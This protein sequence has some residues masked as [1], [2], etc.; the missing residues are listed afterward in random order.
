MKKKIWL[1]KDYLFENTE[2]YTAGSTLYSLDDQ[3][4]AYDIWNR[5]NSLVEKN[6]TLFDLTDGITNLK[7]SINHRLKLIEKMYNFKKI[8]F[9]EKP[10][11]YLELL[12]TYN[13]VRPYLIKFVM[14]IRNLIEHNDSPPPNKQRCKELVDMV[15]YFLK[16]TDSIVSRLTTDFEFEVYDKNNNETHYGGTVELDYNTHEIIKLFGWFPS[17]AI[18]TEKREE[19]LCICTNSFHGNEK[20]NDTEYHHDKLDTDL[21]INGTIDTKCFDYHS[22]ILHLLTSAR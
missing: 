22:L 9:P 8:N 3:Q 18:S 16:S 14:E 20:W 2:W 6:E 21:Y 7:R 12:E 1:S 15:W 19:F 17:G 5:A 11:G 10:K 4:R 13:I